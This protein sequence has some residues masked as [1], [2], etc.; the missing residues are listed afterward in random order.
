MEISAIHFVCLP[1]EG[2]EHER[3]C[4][5]ETEINFL[6]LRLFLHIIILSVFQVVFPKA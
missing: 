5:D 3:E 2:F 4:V 6:E 1:F